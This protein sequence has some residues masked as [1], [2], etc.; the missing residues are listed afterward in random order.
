M[1]GTEWQVALYALS[2]LCAGYGLVSW[3]IDRLAAK[4]AFVVA[5]ASL[6]IGASL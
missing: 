1:T 5:A 2:L 6:L 3:L 4:G